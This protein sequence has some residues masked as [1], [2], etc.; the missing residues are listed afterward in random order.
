MALEAARG[1]RTLARVAD[2][3]EVQ[4]VPGVA[5]HSG[6]E[7]GAQD[8]L[9]GNSGGA[10]APSHTLAGKNTGITVKK[11]VKA[12]EE[13]AGAQAGLKAVPMSP[14]TLRRGRTAAS[15]TTLEDSVLVAVAA[16]ARHAVVETT[17]G[18]DTDVPT[19]SSAGLKDAER[20]AGSDASVARGDTDGGDRQRTQGQR[21]PGALA[22]PET[23][24]TLRSGTS[25][26]PGVG[27]H[28]TSGARSVHFDAK[29][30]DS[31]MET[32]SGKTGSASSVADRPQ[33]PRSPRPAK[34]SAPTKT[35]T[36][37]PKGTGRGLTSASAPVGGNVSTF[38]AGRTRK[39]QKDAE[40]ASEGEPSS[41]MKTRRTK[42]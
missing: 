42:K 8:A 2:A 19:V 16:P 41:P 18:T 14:P 12:R 3:A 31:A 21:L 32:R 7:A 20:T 40:C 36:A 1:L 29:L 5:A 6:G 15:S 13:P 33:S 11:A 24:R 27:K 30:P 26:Q 23:A 38:V 39:R 25:Q 10:E 37:P 34:R 9:G 22:A 4:T 28:T 35:Q 17:C